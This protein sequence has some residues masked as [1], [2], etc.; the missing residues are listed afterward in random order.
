VLFAVVI[1][2]SPLTIWRNIARQAPIKKFMHVDK[3]LVIFQ[4]TETDQY[5]ERSLSQ[6]YIGLSP[7]PGFCQS[8]FYG[9]KD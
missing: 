3:T 1:S 4:A 6:I 2:V 8:I 5:N 9:S 7:F